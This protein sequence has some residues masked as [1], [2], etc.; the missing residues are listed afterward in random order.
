MNLEL[1]AAFFTPRLSENAVRKVNIFQNTALKNLN[2][3][4]SISF[5]LQK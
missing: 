3:I 1:F 4:E 5:S 2:F